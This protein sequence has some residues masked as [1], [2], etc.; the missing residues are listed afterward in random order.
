[1]KTPGSRTIV[2]DAM[3]GDRA[4]EAPVAAAASLSRTTDLRIL[5]VGDRSRIEPLLGRSAADPERIELVDA[6]SAVAMDED[7]R[8]SLERTDSSIAVAVGI[9][10]KGEADALVSAGNT[11]AT[12][13]HVGRAVRR[14]PGIRRTALAAVHPTLPRPH[15]EDPFALLLDVGANLTCTP[16]DLLQFALM[17]SAYASRISKVTRPTVGLLNIGEE[18]G[19]G[20]ECLRRAHELL[21][22]APGIH[23]AGNVEG[24]AVPLGVV[25]VVVCPGLLGNVVLKLLESQGEILE[26]FVRRT[27]SKRLDWRVGAR[28][29]QGA[30]DRI[31]RSFDYASYG[32]APILGFERIVIKAHGRSHPRALENAVKVAAKAVRDDVCGAIA[33]AAAALEAR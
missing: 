30:I 14:I 26:A 27:L 24:R 13:L 23:F 21:R 32:G 2:L 20:D 18:A 29:L 5:L 33:S 15:N 28:L 17:G 19:K 10:A 7:P 6:T 16:E 22:T 25:D 9:L 8:A 1:M 12:L 31:T 3:G 11:G 4:P